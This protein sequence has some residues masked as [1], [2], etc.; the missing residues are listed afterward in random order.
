[1]QAWPTINMDDLCS[2]TSNE[3]GD[4]SCPPFSP[5][6][7]P[8]LKSLSPP[9]SLNSNAGTDVHGVQAQGGLPC[10]PVAVCGNQACSTEKDKL[11]QKLHESEH[12]LHC[13]KIFTD[14]WADKYHELHIKLTELTTVQLQ[15][16]ESGSTD[17]HQQ[18]SELEKL[19]A[20]LE[21]CKA[22][23]MQL[24][25]NLTEANRLI[26]LGIKQ[27]ICNQVHMGQSHQSEK[28]ESNHQ[29]E[30]IVTTNNSFSKHSRRRPHSVWF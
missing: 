17:D 26:R 11:F 2:I 24:T 9:A 21:N 6:N 10:V 28:S 7:F 25:Q 27:F 22:H 1:M 20:E 30:C 19:Q 23:N 29:N 13:Y 5:S 12:K 8:G 3:S 4:R 14:D 18:F 16:S 15:T